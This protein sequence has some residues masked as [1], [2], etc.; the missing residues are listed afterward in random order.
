M[1]RTCA[2]LSKIAWDISV[3]S[4]ELTHFT[5]KINYS[6]N[7]TILQNVVNVHIKKA[8]CPCSLLRAF[9]IMS[10][11]HEARD[12]LTRAI[13]NGHI[14]QPGLAVKISLAPSVK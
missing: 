13:I 5:G 9:C 8:D 12:M 11:P 10:T 14:R 1:P 6:L 4:D 3:S 7:N 2:S